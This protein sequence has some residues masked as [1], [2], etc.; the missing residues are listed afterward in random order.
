MASFGIE[1]ERWRLDD[2]VIDAR[3]QKIFRDTDRIEL[4]QLSFRFLLALIRAAPSVLSVDDLMERVWPG[5]FVN[6]ETVTQ[7]A[8]LLRDALG[9]D[10]RKPRYFAVRRGVGYQLIPEPVAMGAPGEKPKI[11]MWRY[12]GAI[13]LALAIAIAGASYGL[14]QW[15]Q[16]HAVPA[17]AGLRV[18]VLPFDN[19][20]NDPADAFIARSIP[21]I[22]LNRLS[23]LR[24]LTVI[25]RDSALLSQAATAEPKAAAQQLKAAFVVKGS[26]QRTGN[27]LRVTCFVIDTASGA[28]L[29]SERFDWPVDRLYALQDRIAERVA[30]SL[31]SKARGLGPL[32]PAVAPTRSSDAY[33][34]YL[35][36]KAL[37]G[38]L[39]RRRNRC[40]GPAV[41]PGG[42]ARS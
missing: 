37:A 13:A 3:A 33:L 31:E 39:Y 35:R 22:V 7:R 2:L 24:G 8:K 6:A 21:E 42:A 29:W 30:V 17:A 5:I 27:M 20:S 10:P 25:S 34:A 40:G 18:A 15:R 1:N 9:D 41:R 12:K 38:A 14:V 26:V 11:L 4:P 23:S 36:G 19:L 28:R 32:P 16:V